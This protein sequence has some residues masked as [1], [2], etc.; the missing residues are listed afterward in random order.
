MERRKRRR[1]RLRCDWSSDVCSSYL[2][3]GAVDGRGGLFT[4]EALRTRR[5]RG[6]G[7]GGKEGRRRDMAGC[8]RSGEG[9]G[10]EERGEG[11]KA[12]QGEEN[13][14]RKK[15]AATGGRGQRNGRF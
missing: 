14:E 15:A 7:K 8:R 11:L 9:C 6:E 12:G 5:K 1:T 4:A 13:G 2:G 10:G 3:W